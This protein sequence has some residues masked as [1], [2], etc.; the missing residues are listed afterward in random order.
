MRLQG[1]SE[2]RIPITPAAIEPATL[3]LV[4]Q[5]PKQLLVIILQGVKENMVYSKQ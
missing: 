1:F 3:R 4:A 2:L 5:W